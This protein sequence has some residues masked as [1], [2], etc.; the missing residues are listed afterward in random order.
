MG[1][2]MATGPVSPGRQCSRVAHTVASVG[3]YSL[4]SRVAGRQAWWRSTRSRGQ[5]SPATMASSS[6]ARSAQELD[7]RI[8]LHCEGIIDRKSVVK[9]K[10][11]SGREA[12]GGRRDIKKKK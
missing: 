7:E 12:F 11:V 1:R 8:K 5:A 9:G 2:P 4:Q 3:P 10:S 6:P